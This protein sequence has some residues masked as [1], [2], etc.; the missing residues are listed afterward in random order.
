MLLIAGCG[1]TLDRA[2][3]MTN[4]WLSTYSGACKD[5]VAGIGVAVVQLLDTGSN[6]FT[7]FT[8]AILEIEPPVT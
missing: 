7:V 1:T 6:T 5:R 3:P 8:P 2:P 4:S